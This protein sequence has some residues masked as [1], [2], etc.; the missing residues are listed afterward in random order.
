[1]RIIIALT[2]LG[3]LAFTNATPHTHQEISN[4]DDD[5]WAKKP[6]HTTNLMAGKARST[7]KPSTTYTQIPTGFTKTRAHNGETNEL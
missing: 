2:L 6:M 5:F 7:I 4:D 1:M 3:M